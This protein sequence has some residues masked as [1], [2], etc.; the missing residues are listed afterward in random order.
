MCVKA[1]G[2]STR[3]LNQ[4]SGHKSDT[5]GKTRLRHLCPELLGEGNRGRATP[6]G[7]LVPSAAV[8]TND[9]PRSRSWRGPRRLWGHGLQTDSSRGDVRVSALWLLT[10][11]VRASSRGEGG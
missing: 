10:Q 1:M 11:L 8:H 5:H 9:W 2:G 4:V 6:R 3:P 7:V